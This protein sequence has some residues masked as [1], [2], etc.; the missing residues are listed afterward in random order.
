MMVF[1]LDAHR[2]A[3]EMRDPG[4]EHAAQRRQRRLAVVEADDQVVAFVALPV[5]VR[6]VLVQ[7]VQFRRAQRR[8]ALLQQLA[9]RAEVGRNGVPL[10]RFVVGGH[11][12]PVVLDRNALRCETAFRPRAPASPSRRR[13]GYGAAGSA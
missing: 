13:P 8:A 10:H 11:H 5:D 1:H 9:E 2:R 3:Q 12:L 4:F 6:V 7:H